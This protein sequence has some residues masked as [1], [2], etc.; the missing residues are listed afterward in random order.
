MSN[1][2]DP[3]LLDER[4]SAPLV[5]AVCLGDWSTPLLFPL[6]FSVV[7]YYFLREFLWLPLR[8]LRP[9]KARA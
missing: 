9:V 8:F 2:Q 7:S 4:L 6:L 3:W 5:W 1:D